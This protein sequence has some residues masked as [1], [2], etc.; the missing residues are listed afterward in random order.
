MFWGIGGGDKVCLMMGV[1]I[2]GFLLHPICLISG[3]LPCFWG[4]G[5][6]RTPVFFFSCGGG[7]IDVQLLTPPH[8]YR[9]TSTA[10]KL[11]Y[12]NSQ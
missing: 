11:R 1:E 4:E 12:Q 9:K 10:T 8:P 2:G 3:I 6:L 5:S 7:I